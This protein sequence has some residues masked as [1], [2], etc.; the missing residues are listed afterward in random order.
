MNK[1]DRK[2]NSIAN[3]FLLMWVLCITAPVSFF[4]WFYWENGAGMPDDTNGWGVVGDFVGGLSNPF[5]SALTF[6]ALIFTILQNQK[7]LR[8]NEEE[9][10][11]TRKEIELTRQ[12]NEI[13]AEEFRKQNEQ[14][15]EESEVN[16]MS[17]AMI[18]LSD[19]MNFEWEE[20][21][22]SVTKATLKDITLELSEILNCR[23]EEGYATAQHS[24]RIVDEFIPFAVAY[25]DLLINLY[26]VHRENP[27]FY[28]MKVTQAQ[29]LAQLKAYGYL[30]I[31]FTE[32]DLVTLGAILEG[33][34]HRR[35]EI[36][37]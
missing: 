28:A 1:E 9:L 11:E 8:I 30:D 3:G 18:R 16:S 34:D 4:F 36:E 23:A 37:C 15:R 26:L 6:L 25:A 33:Y 20:V 7:V 27:M 21:R 5:I 29:C 14:L 22:D 31:H 24:K 12:A 35:R 17:Q 2:L 19:K 13:Q 10:A 32:G